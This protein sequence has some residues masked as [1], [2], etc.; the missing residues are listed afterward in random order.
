MEIIVIRYKNKF[1][2]YKS[3][4]IHK[5]ESKNNIFYQVQHVTYL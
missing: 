5:N 4:L 2:P 3:K 1:N